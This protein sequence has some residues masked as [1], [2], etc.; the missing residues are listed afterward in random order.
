MEGSVKPDQHATLHH[1]LWRGE[2]EY[3]PG[4]TTHALKAL[5]DT[6]QDMTRS[7]AYQARLA[8]AT[9]ELEQKRAARKRA[10][11][12]AAREAKATQAAAERQAQAQKALEQKAARQQQA[13]ELIYQRPG[14]YA[15]M[16]RRDAWNW[17]IERIARRHGWEAAQ[18]VLI[19][20]GAEAR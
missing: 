14:L 12:Q 2:T 5:H 11:Q 20:E 16:R 19:A 15:D 1:P 17:P 18:W 8:K 7:P 3:G 4:D 10:E 13:M 6:L 9:R